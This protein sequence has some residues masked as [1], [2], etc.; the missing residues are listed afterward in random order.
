MQRDQTDQQATQLLRLDFTEIG[1]KPEPGRVGVEEGVGAS[2]DIEEVKSKRMEIV[3]RACVM[4]RPVSLA[5]KVE[6][7][8]AIQ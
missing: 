2:G 6:Q 3:L 5:P 8:M 7:R 1:Q 4:I